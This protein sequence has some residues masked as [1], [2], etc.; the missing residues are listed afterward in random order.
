MNVLDLDHLAD[1]SINRAFAL[2][3]KSSLLSGKS[4]VEMPL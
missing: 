4:I 2:G 3:D 1:W